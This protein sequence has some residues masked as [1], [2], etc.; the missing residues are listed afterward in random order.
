MENRKKNESKIGVQEK[1][2]D[3][4]RNVPFGLRK[5]VSGYDELKS[6]VDSKKRAKATEEQKGIR[7]EAEAKTPEKRKTVTMISSKPTNA[8]II[9]KTAEKTPVETKRRAIRLSFNQVAHDFGLTKEQVRTTLSANFSPLP[10]YIGEEEMDFLFNVL[11]KQ[12]SVDELSEPVKAPEEQS[13][14]EKKSEEKDAKVPIADTSGKIYNEKGKKDMYMPYTKIKSSESRNSS[15]ETVTKNADIFSKLLK[16]GKVLLLDASF[17]LN[18]R[19]DVRLYDE[20]M[21]FSE[22]PGKI[23]LLPGS[24]HELEKHLPSSNEK[25]YLRARRALEFF[26][27]CT[28]LVCILNN[29]YVDVFGDLDI[30]STLLMYRSRYSFAV[31]TNDTALAKDVLLLNQLHS[32]KGWPAQTY[33]LNTKGEVQV[34]RIKQDDNIPGVTAMP[35]A[36]EADPRPA[37]GLLPDIVPTKSYQTAKEISHSR[38]H[39]TELKKAKTDRVSPYHLSIDMKKAEIQTPIN[40]LQNEEKA[41]NL[42]KADDLLENF[43][44]GN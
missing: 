40:D 16:D 39:E 7:A 12:F 11:T 43:L 44:N 30:L 42:A 8:D 17:L 27:M 2:S 9:P 19:L 1:S 36:R 33:K 26:D 37:L 4:G 22:T 18:E 20:L 35:S 32:Y 28:Q 3:F 25:L 15:T 21:R 38:T 24:V 13:T 6:Y 29:K 10:R 14:A 23:L 41:N 31:F 34:F 5:L